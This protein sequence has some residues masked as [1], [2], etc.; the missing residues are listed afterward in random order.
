MPTQPLSGRQCTAQMSGGGGD[1]EITEAAGPAYFLDVGRFARAG[2]CLSERL[3]AARPRRA[4][5]NDWD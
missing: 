2:T 1:G 5:A 4:V 3:D